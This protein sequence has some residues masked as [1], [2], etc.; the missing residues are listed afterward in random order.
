MPEVDLKNLVHWLKSC[1]AS[2]AQAYDAKR[3]KEDILWIPC[4]FA[5]ASASPPEGVAEM[6]L[7][8]CTGL[9]LEDLSL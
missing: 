8:L 9:R 5:S 2:E 4:A 6:R 7:V 1:S 3:A